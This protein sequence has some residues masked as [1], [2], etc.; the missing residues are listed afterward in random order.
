MPRSAA[1]DDA[2][3]FDL[4]AFGEVGGVEVALMKGCAVELDE[5]GL[6]AEAELVEHR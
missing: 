1:G 5:D 6:S 3:E 2:D 4:V